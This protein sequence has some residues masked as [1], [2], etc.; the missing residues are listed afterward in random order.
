MPVKPTA[1]RGVRAPESDLSGPKR[2]LAAETP[3]GCTRR[4]G[5]SCPSPTERRPSPALGTIC[6]KARAKRAG[7]VRSR[8]SRPASA[9]S[10]HRC[11]YRSAPGH[12]RG[13]HLRR[14]FPQTQP[15]ASWALTEV[16]VAYR[17]SARLPPGSTHGGSHVKARGPRTGG[18]GG[19]HRPSFLGAL[20][21]VVAAPQRTRDDGPGGARSESPGTLA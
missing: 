4:S 17:D 15:A 14:R 12:G 19:E 5:G 7:R 3:R 8:E 18:R 9:R 20:A 13:W 1:P 21:R 6:V 16:N 10:D 11:R 2:C